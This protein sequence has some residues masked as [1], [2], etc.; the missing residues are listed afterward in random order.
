MSK[1]FRKESL[2]DRLMSTTLWYYR[3]NND[4]PGR[5]KPDPETG[6]LK[7]WPL[8]KKQKA[9]LNKLWLDVYNK[10]SEAEKRALPESP[11]YRMLI[12][13]R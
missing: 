1:S 4:H 3:K 2:Y 10:G 7:F 13:K 11:N 6:E 5:P 12:P 9:W 8:S